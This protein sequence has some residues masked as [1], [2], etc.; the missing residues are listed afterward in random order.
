MYWYEEATTLF[1]SL[2]CIRQQWYWLGYIF[3]LQGD[4]FIL[5]EED[6]SE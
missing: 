1:Q 4:N 2:C 3:K 5:D 6:L